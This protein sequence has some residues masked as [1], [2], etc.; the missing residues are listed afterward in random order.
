[1]SGKIARRNSTLFHA[2]KQ[3]WLLSTNLLRLFSRKL[4]SS[5]HSCGGDRLPLL[6]DMKPLSPPD[7]CSHKTQSTSQ[8]RKSWCLIQET[9]KGF[10]RKFVNK[11]ASASCE[12]EPATRKHQAKLAGFRSP[13]CNHIVDENSDFLDHHMRTHKSSDM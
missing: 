12:I 10:A 8:K 6:N 5:S 13:P 2:L 1:M 3:F 7:P 9:F 4:F 11:S